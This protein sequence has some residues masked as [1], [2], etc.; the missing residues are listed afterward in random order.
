VPDLDRGEEAVIRRYSNSWEGHDREAL[1]GFEP[2]VSCQVHGTGPAAMT[3]A[4]QIVLLLLTEVGSVAG[5]HP[6]I[7]GRG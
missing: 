4:K 7:S 6:A 1:P 5:R 3:Q 2:C